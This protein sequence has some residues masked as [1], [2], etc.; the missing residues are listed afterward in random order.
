MVL[1]PLILRSLFT[2]YLLR[3]PCTAAKVLM[4]YLPSRLIVSRLSA[5][6]SVPWL[7]NAAATARFSATSLVWSFKA[8]LLISPTRLL[9]SPSIDIS[10]LPTV[11]TPCAIEISSVFVTLSKER[12]V[13][14]LLWI[15]VI[16][17]PACNFLSFVKVK[18]FTSILA[19]D[20]VPS[21]LAFVIFNTIPLFSH[22]NPLNV[23]LLKFFTL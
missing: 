23:I 7:I 22:S 3:L 16:L 18:L 17:S 12:P 14:R 4:P 1:Q 6:K 5:I 19:P 21:L 9:V 13:S 10:I 11:A 2:S 15:K 8:V 20:K